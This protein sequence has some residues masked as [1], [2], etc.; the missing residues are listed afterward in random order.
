MIYY[1]RP[2]KLE[3]TLLMFLAQFHYSTDNEFN[4]QEK[5]G[6][7]TKSDKT[8]PLLNL[9]GFLMACLVYVQTLTILKKNW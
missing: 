7:S 6:A 1:C 9:P 2:L 3:L 4:I 5:E 8:G